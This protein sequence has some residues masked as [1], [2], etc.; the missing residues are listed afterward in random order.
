MNAI[1]RTSKKA[2][3]KERNDAKRKSDMGQKKEREMGNEKEN[4]AGFLIIFVIATSN[5]NRGK[6]DMEKKESEIV[7]LA[8]KTSLGAFLMSCA[9]LVLAL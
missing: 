6:T 5:V 1:N 9:R 2:E 4:I 7:S 3:E 8:A